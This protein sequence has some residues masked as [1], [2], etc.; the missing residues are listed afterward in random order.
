MAKE[1]V[2]QRGRNFETTLKEFSERR[3]YYNHIPASRVKCRTSGR[4]WNSYHKFCVERNPWDKT[5]SH[6]YMVN[7]RLKVPLTLEEYIA[8]DIFCLDS[9]IYL[10]GSGNIMVDN[11]IRYE[12]LI[13]D[14]GAQFNKL[15]IPFDGT[16]GFDAKSEL[17]KDRRHYREV[18][19]DSEGVAISKVFH[20]EIEL[21]D[22]KY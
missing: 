8:K 22:Y 21:F 18:F 2:Y 15:N 9:P 12:N 1:L 4:I 6:L 17:R 19:S 11:V 13:D 16:L 14:L 3:Q 20:K 10:D 5:I 7:S